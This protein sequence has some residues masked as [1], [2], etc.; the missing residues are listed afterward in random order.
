[1]NIYLLCN[2]RMILAC[3]PSGCWALLHFQ[4]PSLHRHSFVI[5]VEWV[6][7]TKHCL[8]ILSV[9]VLHLPFTIASYMLLIL[10]LFFFFFFVLLFCN[11]LLLPT[12]FPS[13]VLPSH[14]A[15]ILNLNTSHLNPKYPP[16][17]L[18]PRSNNPPPPQ[19]KISPPHPT[20]KHRPAYEGQEK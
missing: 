16:L 9:S 6:S 1:M 8:F 4:L 15:C 11:L 5:S 7:R 19:T 17:I 3:Y 10:R 13:P 18:N 12:V 20:L 14:L 2:D